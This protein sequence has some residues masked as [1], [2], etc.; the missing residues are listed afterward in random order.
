VK[1]ARFFYGPVIEA[2]AGRPNG[3]G[4]RSSHLVTGEKTFRV[5]PIPDFSIWGIRRIS[6]HIVEQIEK[7]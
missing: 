5:F 2:A 4:S 7:M 1:S 6:E 3:S